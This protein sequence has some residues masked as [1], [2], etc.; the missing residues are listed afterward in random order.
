MSGNPN[1]DLGCTCYRLRMAARRVSRLYDR[2]LAPCGISVAQFGL[3]T[4]I[5][6]NEGSSVTALAHQL[7]MERTTLTR[8]L[9]PLER[10]GYVRVDAG[11]D[12]R[13][14][15]VRITR[16]GVELLSRAIPL[17]LE[18]QRELEDSAGRA[19]LVALNKALD[20][21]IEILPRD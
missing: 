19:E 6:A 12:Q 8:N 9:Q 16:T 7:E 10:D 2:H 14:R 4:A 11:P 18:A 21:T 17:W 3:L 1:A 15:A 13:T 20:R 5:R